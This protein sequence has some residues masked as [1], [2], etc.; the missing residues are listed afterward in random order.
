[1]DDEGMC[2]LLLKQGFST[3]ERARLTRLRRDY[4]ARGVF[5]IAGGDLQLEDDRQAGEVDRSGQ[6][7]RQDEPAMTR[8]RHVGLLLIVISAVS[9]G[10]MPVFVRFAYA[11]GADAITVLLLRFG[12]AAVVMAAI[13]AAVSPPLGGIGSPKDTVIR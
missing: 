7:T 1:M 8:Q 4:A 3:Q 12:I 6:D 2:A 5:D 9:F 10:V 11:A 13:R